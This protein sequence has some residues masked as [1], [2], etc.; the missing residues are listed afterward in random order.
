MGPFDSG[1]AGHYQ[2]STSKITV[3]MI[4]QSCY[5]PSTPGH[6]QCETSELVIVTIGQA[7]YSPT[8]TKYVTSENDW[9]ASIV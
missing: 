6:Y 7:L 4:D 1:K 3:I 9:A 2:Y 5:S 8:K